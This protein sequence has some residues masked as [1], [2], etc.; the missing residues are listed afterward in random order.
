[1]FV[2]L[3]VFY[4]INRK[5]ATHRDFDPRRRRRRNARPR[6]SATQTAGHSLRWAGSFFPHA[7]R[8]RQPVLPHRG[9][10]R[11]AIGPFQT[12]EQKCDFLLRF[13]HAMLDGLHENPY[14]VVNLNQSDC[15]ISLHGGALPLNRRGPR[16][17][18]TPVKPR[19][20]RR[21]FTCADM[22]YPTLFAI[23]EAA[24][25]AEGACWRTQSRKASTPTAPAR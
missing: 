11:R 13:V 4:G 2:A 20:D 3:P 7:L 1:M 14:R 10:N 22:I 15:V 6:S 24:G 9:I 19:A 16:M 12:G 18:L 25:A 23:Y 8:C 21:R 17:T 5:G